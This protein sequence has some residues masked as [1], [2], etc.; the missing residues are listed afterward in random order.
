MS[1]GYVW[2][3]YKDYDI[4]RTSADGSNVVRLTDTPGYDAEGT[5][6]S[7]D[8]SIVFTSV[9]DGDLELYRMD[10]DGK[11]LRRLTN[12]PGYDGGA[13]FSADCSKIVWRASRPKPGKELDEYRAHLAQGLVKPSKLEIWVA[14][15]DGSDARQI[16]YLGAAS[17]APFFF[18][19]GKRV[20]F[21]S[22]YGDPHGREFDLWAVN[23]DGTR[24]ERITFAPGFD[25]FPMFSPD[26]TRL[27]FSSNRA[28]PPGAHETDLYVA[29]WVDSAP[30]AEMLAPDRIRADVVWLAD[31][32]REGRGI[33]SVGLDAAGEFLEHRM[34]ELGLLPVQDESYRRVFN[35]PVGVRLERS[36]ALSIGGVAVAAHE[37]T[38]PGFS[39]SSTVEGPLVLAG[40]GI[41]ARPRAG[42]TTLA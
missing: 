1:Q 40:Y 29:R 28:F 25:G 11:N 21:S 5:V 16:T 14:N 4:F 26:G 36:S 9:R 33:G 38:A 35:V 41:P 39:T 34:R 32:G 42:M 10:V 7:K 12:A 19:D 6:C 8:G 13:F 15:A 22:N 30:R 27:A 31:P 37:F 2:A 20:I 17:F 24:L 23:V 3:L 18:P